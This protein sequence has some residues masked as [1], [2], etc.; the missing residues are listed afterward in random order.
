MPYRRV[1][2]S[3]PAVLRFLAVE[4]LDQRGGAYRRR[5]RSSA[6]AITS[7]AVSVHFATANGTATAGSD[8]TAVSQDVSF[9]A[10]ETSKT[11]SIP[12][13]DDSSIEGDEDRLPLA[14]QPVSRVPL[15][16]S[17]STATLTIVDND[18]SFAFSKTYYSVSEGR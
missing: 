2:A 12:I 7:S 16:A 10:G 6:P 18:G 5:S 8:Y 13:I 11:V 3:R 14:L 1:S 4:L 9:A 17:P 15:W